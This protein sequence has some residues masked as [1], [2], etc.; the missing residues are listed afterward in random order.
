MKPLRLLEHDVATRELGERKHE[1]SEEMKHRE[2][3]NGLETLY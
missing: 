3:E 2:R 1:K